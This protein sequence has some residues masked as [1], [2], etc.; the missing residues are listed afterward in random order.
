MFDKRLK[1][2]FR[3]SSN[4][5]NTHETSAAQ[6]NDSNIYQVTKTDA[7]MVVGDQGDSLVG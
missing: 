6:S 1:Y 5:I 3:D 2:F 7:R 4:V